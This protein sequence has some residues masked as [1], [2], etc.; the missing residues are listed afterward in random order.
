[1]FIGKIFPQGRVPVLILVQLVPHPTWWPGTREPR[2]TTIIHRK[3][4]INCFR[5]FLGLG[6][7]HDFWGF[8]G[9]S[10]SFIPLSMNTIGEIESA[11]HMLIVRL[12]EIEARSYDCITGTFSIRSIVFFDILKRCFILVSFVWARLFWRIAPEFF[13][14]R[15]LNNSFLK[16]MKFA[17][18]KKLASETI[19]IL[20]NFMSGKVRKTK[21]VNWERIHRRFV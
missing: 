2:L 8:F 14:L 3:H 21:T 11:G 6:S 17:N 15:A 10:R 16:E 1:M 5:S 20:V 9:N 7:V 12:A 19:L 18:Q 4:W 13:C